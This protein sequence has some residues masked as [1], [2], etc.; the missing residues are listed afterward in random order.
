MSDMLTPISSTLPFFEGSVA[1]H[2]NCDVN[3]GA[4]EH[5]LQINHIICRAMHV[6]RNPI[7]PQPAACMYA[8]NI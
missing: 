7:L 6:P 2:P 1:T 8:Q 5:G 4:E 3:Q